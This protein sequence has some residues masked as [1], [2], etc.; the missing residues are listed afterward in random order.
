MSGKMVAR[1]AMLLHLLI[2]PAS[3]VI[4]RQC[5]SRGKVCLTGGEALSGNVLVGGRPVC[6]DHW[7]IRDATVVCRN[8]GHARATNFTTKAFYGQLGR[9]FAMDNVKELASIYISIF[10]NHNILI[11]LTGWSSI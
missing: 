1:L 10:V 7:D 2:S 6:D 4:P 3:S 9:D 5:L 8:L 11:I